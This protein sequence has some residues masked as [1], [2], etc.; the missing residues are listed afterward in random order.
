MKCP[1]CGAAELLQDTRDLPYVYK[2]KST[3]IPCVTGEFCSE[4]GE[5]VLTIAQSERVS[6]AMLDFNKQVNGDLADPFFI[7]R[8]RK[9]L[10]LDQKEAAKL[11][12]GGDNAF[13]RYENGKTSLHNV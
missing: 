1:V 11:F 8:V 4:C 12:G 13:S 6:V 5:S 7:M 10:K 3:V 2:G 9:K